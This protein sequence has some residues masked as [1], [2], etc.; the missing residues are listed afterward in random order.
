MRKTAPAKPGWHT[1]ANAWS[2]CHPLTR[3]AP[4]RTATARLSAAANTRCWAT[5][6]IEQFMAGHPVSRYRLHSA[7]EVLGIHPR[8]LQRQVA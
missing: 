1:S 6:A 4:P 8:T 2:K 7:C 3:R 5:N